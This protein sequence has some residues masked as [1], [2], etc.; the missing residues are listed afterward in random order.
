MVLMIKNKK[1]A[2]PKVHF[3][4]FIPCSQCAVFESDFTGIKH[5][6]Y[7][8]YMDTEIP[9]RKK[10]IPDDDLLQVVHCSF[11]EPKVH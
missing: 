11:F 6:C 8:A 9:E 2:E 3:V 1:K 5:P 7:E 4:K 10:E